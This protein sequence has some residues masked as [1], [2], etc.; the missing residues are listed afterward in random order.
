MCCRTECGD[1]QVINGNEGGWCACDSF[2]WGLCG[3]KIGRCSYTL[4]L[5][6][7]LCRQVSETTVSEETGM[8]SQ[9]RGI[10]SSI[11]GS[12]TVM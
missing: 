4:A 2:A 12:R 8:R 10:S 9:S 6:E 3:K 5:S 11:T 7:C 1:R